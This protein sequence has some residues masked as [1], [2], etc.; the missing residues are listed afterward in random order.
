M[1]RMY[2]FLRV[3]THPFRALGVT[4]RGNTRWEFSCVCTIGA[5]LGGVTQCGCFGNRQGFLP[6]VPCEVIHFLC[7]FIPHPEEP[8]FH[9]SRALMFH[10]DV[11][12]AYCCS[13]VA[14]YGCVWLRVAHICQCES[15]NNTCLA[16]VIQCT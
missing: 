9:R 13:T 8:H 12:N 11:C 1:L 15:K 16:I 14:M 5:L 7:N 4:A 6:W 10:G 2:P 3:P